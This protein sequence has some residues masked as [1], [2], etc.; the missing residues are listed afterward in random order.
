MCAEANTRLRERLCPYRSVHV[1][2][3]KEAVGHTQKAKNRFAAGRARW[4]KC[5]LGRD[6]W[7]EAEEGLR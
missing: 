7:M 4:L 2:Q 6:R 5:D 1:C 3:P